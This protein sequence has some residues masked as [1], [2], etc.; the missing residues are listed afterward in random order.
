MDAKVCKTED[1]MNGKMELF[2]VACTQCPMFYL[3]RQD[4]HSGSPNKMEGDHLNIKIVYSSVCCKANSPLI[5][6]NV[7]FETNIRKMQPKGVPT[8]KTNKKHCILSKDKFLRKPRCQVK[9]R[10]I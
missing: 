7:R 5:C 6:G 9:T 3:N 4:M 10:E 8:L 2:Y 1:W